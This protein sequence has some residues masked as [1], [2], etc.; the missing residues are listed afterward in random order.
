MDRP[1]HTPPEAADFSAQP[2]PE[3]FGNQLRAMVDPQTPAEIAAFNDSAARVAENARVLY[4]GLPPGST[5]EVAGIRITGDESDASDGITVYERPDD[6][7]FDLTLEHRARQGQTLTDGE[8][9]VLQERRER[10]RTT[11]ER[12][13]NDLKRKGPTSPWRATW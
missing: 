13:R 10:V 5:A 12:L 7:R 11:E 4:E 3:E 2:S 8:K 1:R 9:Q 6:S